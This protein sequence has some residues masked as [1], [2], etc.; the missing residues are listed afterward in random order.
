M[1]MVMIVY[2]SIY[3]EDISA[4]LEAMAGLGFTRFERVSGRGPASGPRLDTAVWPGFNRVIM[5]ALEDEP[6]AALTSALDAL[7]GRRS[8]IRVY[9]WPAAELAPG[10]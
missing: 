3:D 6:L 2:D 4:V 7:P 8:G 9:A 1:Q 5:T 10:Q